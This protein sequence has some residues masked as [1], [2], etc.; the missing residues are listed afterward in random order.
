MC[1]GDGVTPRTAALFAFRTKWQCIAVDP[2][3]RVETE[4]GSW[5][6]VSRLQIRA[7]MIEETAPIKARKLLVVCVHAHVGL[8]Q[9]LDVMSWESALGIVIMPCCNFYAALKLPEGDEPVVEF[10]DRGVVSPHRL[11]RVY[12]RKCE[13]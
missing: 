7:D 2:I 4:D 5:N 13:I 9:C 3:M 11:I 8:Q 12:R 1:V 10:D 6:G